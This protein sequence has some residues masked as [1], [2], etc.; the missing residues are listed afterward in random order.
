MVLEVNWNYQNK[1]RTCFLLNKLSTRSIRSNEELWS[2]VSDHHS[3][4]KG[5]RAPLRNLADDRLVGRNV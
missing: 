1:L 4:R 5:T 2:E 3:L